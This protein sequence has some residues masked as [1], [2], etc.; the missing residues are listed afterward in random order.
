MGTDKALIEVDGRTLVATAVAALAAAG[1]SP[2]V[3][4]GGNR[5]ALEALDLTCVDDRWPGEGPLGGII[6]ALDSM[7][8]DLVAVLSCDLTDASSIAVRSV[9]GALGDADV[10]VPVVEGQAE[11]LHAIWRR[12]VLPTLE[13]MFAAGVRAPRHAVERLRVAQLLDGDPCWFHDADR[14]EDLPSDSR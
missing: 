13:S 9:M 5:S 2:V 7:D 10:A 4:V 3:V 11:W 12:A 1:A 6:T 14:P 8:T